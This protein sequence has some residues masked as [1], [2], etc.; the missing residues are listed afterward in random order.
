MRGWATRLPTHLS[1]LQQ[2]RYSKKIIL[3]PKRTPVFLIFL[4]VLPN[5]ST[6]SSEAVTVYT[7]THTT[8]EEVS[9]VAPRPFSIDGGVGSAPEPPGVYMIRDMDS[10]RALVLEDSRLTLQRDVG[11][12]GGW[13]WHCVEKHDGWLGFR[14]A[15]SGNYL[16]RDGRGGFYAK[17]SKFDSWEAFVLRPQKAGGYHLM[18]IDWWTLKR[19]GVGGNDGLVEVQTPREAVRWEFIEV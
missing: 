9:P 8:D 7:P 2:T 19:M 11:T 1:R 3:P 16:G 13:R 18:G 6:L 4:C 10:G 15:V 12:N 14:E 17:A 5:M